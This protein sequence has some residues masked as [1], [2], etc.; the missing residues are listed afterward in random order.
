MS[1]KA[2][3]YNSKEP[4]EISCCQTEAE[5]GYRRKGMKYLVIG[6]GG[7]GGALGAYLAK[8]G[9]D[10][11]LIAR[12]AHLAALLANGLRITAFIAFSSAC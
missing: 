4:G 5:I 8:G 1:E 3:C 6:A 2:T 11:A 9:K 7:T 10:V 12:G